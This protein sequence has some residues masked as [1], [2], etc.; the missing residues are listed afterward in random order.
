MRIKAI[1][2]LLVATLILAAT[3]ATQFGRTE[4][5][6]E[7]A[8]MRLLPG[9]LRSDGLYVAAI[10]ITMAPQWKTYWREPG[11]TGIP[12]HFDWSGSGNLA[13]VGYFW[14]RPSVFESFG[15]QTIGYEDSLVLPVLLKPQDPAQPITARLLADFGVCK[16]ICVP[17]AGEDTA[18]L[19]PGN[20]QNQPL[21]EAWI[22][23]RPTPASDAGLLAADCRLRPHGS[24]FILRAHLDFARALPADLSAV[25]MESGQSNLW[26]SQVDHSRDGNAL[27]LEA[28]LRS[29]AE[30]PLMLDRSALR[31]TLISED[32]AIDLRGC[33]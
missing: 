5:S 28:D 27:R 10:E 20:A 6:G 16:D 4:A 23:R 30:G 14:P 1:S 29:Y 11:P 21:I 17:V 31:I 24:D 8:E 15:A 9:W 7:V 33:G 3:A 2:A 26:I 18:T 19:A 13:Q 12:P 32:S 22:D 25:V